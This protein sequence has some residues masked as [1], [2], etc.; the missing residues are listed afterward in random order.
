MIFSRWYW[1]FLRIVKVV[2]M[3]E[4]VFA[5]QFYPS[6]SAGI[7]D[8]VCPRCLLLPMLLKIHSLI[9]MQK[10]DESKE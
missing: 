6:S 9:Q 1:V 3:L 2:E 5:K 7:E 4:E 8:R 10:E